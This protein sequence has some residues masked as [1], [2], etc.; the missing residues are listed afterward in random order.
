MGSGIVLTV[1]EAGGHLPP[2]H[3]LLALHEPGPIG[4]TK[5]E[6]GTMDWVE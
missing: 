4:A 6:G 1:G 5:G 3:L 2:G